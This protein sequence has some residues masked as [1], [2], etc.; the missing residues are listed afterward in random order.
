MVHAIGSAYGYK[1]IL[2]NTSDV[3][4]A[5]AL[6]ISLL[7]DRLMVLASYEPVI[8]KDWMS[9]HKIIRDI[10][11]ITASGNQEWHSLL[12]A[13]LHAAWDGLVRQQQQFNGGNHSS[14]SAAQVYGSIVCRLLHMAL[15]MSFNEKLNAIR[16]TLVHFLNTHVF[17]P[18]LSEMPMQRIV[19]SLHTVTDDADKDGGLYDKEHHL[20]FPEPLRGSDNDDKNDDNYASPSSLLVASGL[21]QYVVALCQQLALEKNDGKEKECSLQCSLL[22]VLLPCPLEWGF[23]QKAMDAEYHKGTQRSQYN[24]GESV[25][26]WHS[27]KG[28]WEHAEILAVDSTVSPPSYTVLLSTGSRETEASRLRSGSSSGLLIDR[29]TTAAAAAPPYSHEMRCHVLPMRSEYEERRALMHV[30]RS[31]PLSADQ[32]HQQQ[33]IEERMVDEIN[34]VCIKLAVAYCDESMF[35]CTGD[36]NDWSRV[37]SFLDRCSAFAIDEL[38]KIIKDISCDIVSL[39]DDIVGTRLDGGVDAAL[40]FFRNLNRRGV[41]ASTVKGTR[42]LETLHKSFE[43]ALWQFEERFAKVLHD[44]MYVYSSILTNIA[45][46]SKT[47]PLTEWHAA[48]AAFCLHVLQ[49]LL[50]YGALVSLISDTLPTGNAAKILSSSKRDGS[51]H[52][53]VWNDIACVARATL[54]HADLAFLHGVVDAI[55]RTLHS[56]FSSHQSLLPFSCDCVDMLLALILTPHPHTTVK[57]TAY[58]VLLSHPL[59]MQSLSMYGDELSDKSGMNAADC[60]TGYEGALDKA[61]EAE[62]ECYAL[63]EMGV[64]YQLSAVVTNSGHDMALVG[65]SILLAHLL[66]MPSESSCRQMLVQC[67][68]DCTGNVVSDILDTVAGKLTLQDRERADKKKNRNIVGPSSDLD[69]L[70]INSEDT[71]SSQFA[72]NMMYLFN[73]GVGISAESIDH[74]LEEDHT[75]QQGTMQQTVHASLLF[76]AMLR[77]LPV[78]CRLWFTNIRDR[79]MSMAIEKFT[80]RGISGGLLTAEFDAV[81]RLAS[82]DRD[83]SFTIRAKPTEREVIASLEIEEGH[84]I[85]LVVKLPEA[86]PLRAAEAQCKKSVGINEARLRTWLLSIT[87]FIRN[88]NDAT[89]GAIRMW[90]K[91]IEKEF[92]GQE[93]CLICF[94]IIHPSTGQIPKSACRTCRQRFHGA[95]LYK[96]FHSS[97]KSNCPH[98]QSPW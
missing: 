49:T 85:E 8:K 29:Y 89:A 27:A 55:D 58:T 98:C 64:R 47:L 51:H 21:P 86:M 26:Y 12:D 96:W 30:L 19:F 84:M 13:S 65:W 63:M 50:L 77:T 56:C 94:S 36:N 74:F 7:K 37:F 3:Q 87:S 66:D 14:H 90:K 52:I 11:S 1:D 71:S 41:L 6:A 59:L 61:E 10:V 16:D 25:W 73:Q 46:C 40:S 33:H 39:A 31:R 4:Q 48:Q 57:Q 83:S 24:K 97:G 15:Q 20:S 23:I 67:I 75:S 92:E 5:S 62:D 68:K 88:R 17:D 78:P 54:A 32:E 82:S 38:L 93:N 60:D 18:E 22:N 53:A 76:A 42:V 72:Q 70:V 2:L 80:A 9:I 95:C 44:A 45:P 79:S 28:E 34:A 91:N 43:A 35:E 69:A 81:E